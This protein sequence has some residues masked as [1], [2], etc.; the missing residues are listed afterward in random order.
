MR[1]AGN[2]QQSKDSKLFSAFA[3]FLKEGST[4]G[5]GFCHHLMHHTNIEVKN[6]M[7]TGSGVYVTFQDGSYYKMYLSIVEGLNT[8]ESNVK[9]GKYA[10]RFR[11]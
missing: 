9:N 2:H 7:Q 3:K 4:S 8:N 5:K 1:K 10:D 11:L 6:A